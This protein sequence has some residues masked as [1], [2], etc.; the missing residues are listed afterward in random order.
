MGLR[1]LA[2]EAALTLGSSREPVWLGSQQS[3]SQLRL[4]TA[5]W[6]NEGDRPLPVGWLVIES[7]LLIGEDVL[8][9]R[10]WITE[11][12]EGFSL[13]DNRNIKEKPGKDLV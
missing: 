2:D 6:T 10:V 1:A 4:S 11:Q 5:V 8:V 7:H 3:L 9:I 12:S 13:K